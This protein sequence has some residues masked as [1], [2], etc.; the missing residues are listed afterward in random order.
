[1]RYFLLLL[2]LL[3]TAGFCQAQL[4]ASFKT[5]LAGR[6]NSYAR[7][8][9]DSVGMSAKEAKTLW[10]LRDNY[11]DRSSALLADSSVAEADKEAAMATLRASFTRQLQAELGAE[12]YERYVAYVQRRMQAHG[13]NG[14][15]LA[16]E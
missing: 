13:R 3:L 16:G 8:L 15:P 11:L 5:E 2:T 12:L 9:Q 7:V 1:M 4:S 10:K 6:D 14:K